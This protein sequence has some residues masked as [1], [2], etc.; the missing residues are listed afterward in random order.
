MF[1]NTLLGRDVISLLVLKKS[2]SMGRPVFMIV[3][4]KELP[5]TAPSRLQA[6]EEWL[7][8]VV[9]PAM[10]DNYEATLTAPVVASRFVE[11]VGWVNVFVVSLVVLWRN[12]SVIDEDGNLIIARGVN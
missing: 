3:V 5:S 7:N 6:V 11:N 1:I 2:K 9:N 8:K 10:P 12:D 4:A